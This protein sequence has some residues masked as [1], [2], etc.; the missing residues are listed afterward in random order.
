MAR[1]IGVGRLLLYTCLLEIG[2]DPRK[3]RC[4][5]CGTVLTMQMANLA[6]PV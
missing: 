2:D 3:V 5:H 1:S 4:F 6:L